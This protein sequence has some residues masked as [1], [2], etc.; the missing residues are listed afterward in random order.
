MRKRSICFCLALILVLGLMVPAAQVRAASSM[1][2]SDELLEVIKA[3][4]GFSGTPY[5]DTDGKYTIGYGTRCPDDM[6]EH[7]NETPMTEEEADAELRRVVAT[8]EAEVNKFIDNN[9]LS[10]EQRQFDAVISLVYNCGSSWLKKGNTLV[11]ALTGGASGNELIFAFSIYSVS[12]GVRSVGHVRR[13]LAEAAIYLEGHYSRT[14][15]DNY[16]FVLY[17]GQG[18][19]VSEYDVQGYDGSLTAAPIASASKSGYIFKGWSLST[20][21]GELVTVLDMDTKGKT[22]YAQWEVDPDAPPAEPT[23]PEVSEGDVIDPV[24]VTITGSQINI[25]KGPGLSYDV[26]GSANKGDQ[27]TIDAVH[28]SDGYTWG[29]CSQGWVALEHTDY[30]K[31][32]Q[33]T[34]PP[35]QPTDPPT[36]PTEPPTEPTD[37]PTV[38]TEP[39]TQPPTEPEEPIPE[40]E[41]IDPVEVKITAKQVNVRKG[42]GLTYASIGRLDKGQKITVTAVYQGSSYLWGECSQGWVALE[43]TDYY[44]VIEPVEPEPP[45]ET[46]PTT[47][48]ETPVEPEEPVQPDVPQEPVQPEGTVIDAQQVQITAKQ[49]NVR[50]GPGLR[51]EIVDHI[52]KGETVSISA[53]YED[54]DYLWGRCGKGWI[55]LENTTYGEQEAPPQEDEP[56]QEPEEPPIQLPEQEPV[57]PPV[58]QETP[59]RV[60]VTNVGTGAQQ[61]LSEPDGYA[62]GHLSPGDKVEILDQVEVAGRKWGRCAKGWIC[63]RS[64]MKLEK[65]ASDQVVQEPETGVIIET[66]ARVQSQE[67]VQVSDAPD[68]ESCGTLSQGDR[69]QI[70]EFKIAQDE[71]W[72]RCGDGWI[73]LRSGIR[74]ETQTEIAGPADPEGCFDTVVINAACMNLRGAA[75]SDA[76]VVC[77]L[78]EGA[79][80]AVYERMPV[81]GSIWA[82]TDL[83]W[84]NMD[85]VV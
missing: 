60:F 56:V 28:T 81:E 38:P 40:G 27:L 83:G 23:D 36:E 43:N 75:G 73:S 72:G 25:R 33:P 85:H 16:C 15:P 42:P 74:L 29:R 49:V 2:S 57:V 39:P 78:Y 52:P 26:V 5:R 19:T 84:I 59:G 37:P 24:K 48:P 80:V 47:E 68:G 30:Q 62:V 6:V 13:R 17:N 50:K 53:V 67:T 7:Y 79:I 12:G 1:V 64:N 65:V 82:R 76:G 71:L 70:L 61:I 3:F 63:I 10:Y 35:T 66:Y 22:L 31:P 46:G 4:E 45:V 69:V 18:G 9:G 32:Q 51:Y 44:D 11:K 41:P 54:S 34:E 55:A 21:G 58:V 20:S 14:A 77:R 8:Y